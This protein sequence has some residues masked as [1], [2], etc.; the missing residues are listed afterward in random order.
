MYGTHYAIRFT[1]KQMVPTKLLLWDA[2]ALL[3]KL[4]FESP[5][6]SPGA[7]SALQPQPCQHK[8]KLGVSRK[9]IQLGH[10]GSLLKDTRRPMKVVVGGHGI[11]T[12]DP[13]ESPMKEIKG[14]VQWTTSW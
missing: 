8:G 7:V 12:T 5:V 1:L 4:N 6:L 2:H 9:G 11:S 13:A 10:P 14:N 3:R